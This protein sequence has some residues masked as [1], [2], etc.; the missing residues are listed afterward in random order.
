VRES[1]AL[2][3]RALDESGVPYQYILFNDNLETQKF[4]KT[5]KK[6]DIKYFSIILENYPTNGLAKNLWPQSGY[7]LHLFFP[8]YTPPLQVIRCNESKR[9]SGN[10]WLIR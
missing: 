4:M 3:L 7:S 1:V 2:N 8:K 10:G 6:S 9:L 5:S